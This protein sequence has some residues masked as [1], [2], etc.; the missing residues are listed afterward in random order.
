MIMS[1]IGAFV[2]AGNVDGERRM[3]D[4]CGAL[5][6]DKTCLSIAD[7]NWPQAVGSAVLKIVV[8]TSRRTDSLVNVLEPVL[9]KLSDSCWDVCDRVGLWN[10]RKSIWF[11]GILHLMEPAFT[12]VIQE[13]IETLDSWTTSQVKPTF[14][15]IIQI[16]P[17]VLEMIPIPVFKVLKLIGGIVPK[18][19][20]PIGGSI[21]THFIFASL[22]GIVD[23]LRSHLRNN[24]HIKREK[25]DF[26]I[27]FGEALCSPPEPSPDIKAINDVIRQLLRGYED[28]E[29]EEIDLDGIHDE[30]SYYLAENVANDL[31][32]DEQGRFAL[33]ALYRFFEL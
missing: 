25:L 3:T 12:P 28:E 4:G 30:S 1:N 5:Q 26:L 13:I 21:E 27:A 18:K 9:R 11:Y 22:Y 19:I 29:I 33:K 32:G 14:N 6:C 8:V 2:P 24:L 15:K 7:I 16:I 10:A 23:R 17:D 20:N 31:L